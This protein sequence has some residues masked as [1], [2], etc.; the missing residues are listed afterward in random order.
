M[1]APALS[2]LEDDLDIHTETETELTLS[3]F[4][5]AYACGPLFLGP[6]EILGR[7]RV[8]Q[9]SNLFYF[10]RNLGCGFSQN[11]VEMLSFAFSA[12]LEEAHLWLLVV[13]S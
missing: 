1:A 9:M 2:K 10:A 6:I 8:L 3:I 4:V 13:R 12:G 7:T 5:L 11:K